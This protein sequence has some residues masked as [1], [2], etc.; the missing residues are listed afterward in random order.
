MKPRGTALQEKL[1]AL[2]L[3]FEA[4]PTPA[5]D[6]QVLDDNVLAM[7]RGGFAERAIQ[8]GVRAP[9]FSMQSTCGSILTLGDLLQKGPVV[10]TWFRG[11]W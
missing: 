9:D 5:E 10:L 2:R 8:S 1:R 7:Q 11:N 4:G 3:E 6:I